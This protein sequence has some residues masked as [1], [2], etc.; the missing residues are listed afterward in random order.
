MAKIQMKV[1]N[2]L[3]LKVGNIVHAYGARFEI[4]EINE[5]EQ[6]SEYLIKAG[7]TKIVSA[8]GKWID[9]QILPGYFGPEKNWNFQGNSGVSQFIEA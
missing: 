6:T 1:V 8:I 7:R 3:D 4:V 5:F 9:G 2:Q